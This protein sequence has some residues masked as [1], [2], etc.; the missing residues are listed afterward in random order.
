[1]EKWCKYLSDEALY[2]E[3]MQ[4]AIFTECWLCRSLSW[5]GAFLVKLSRLEDFIGLDCVKNDIL[6][7]VGAA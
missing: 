4:T 3:W 1:M 7:A 5:F 6:H 2:S